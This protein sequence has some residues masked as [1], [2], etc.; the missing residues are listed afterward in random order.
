MGVWRE[1]RD[2]ET[3]SCPHGAGP[4]MVA[5]VD[6]VLEQAWR[7]S[8][9]SSCKVTLNPFGFRANRKQHMFDFKTTFFQSPIEV[10]LHRKQNVS[11][12]TL[13]KRFLPA[14]ICQSCWCLRR[15]YSFLNREAYFESQPPTAER[16]FRTEFPFCSFYLPVFLLLIG[17]H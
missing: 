1:S 3:L 11:S 2:E 7:H 17:L 14:H 15:R 8:F 10:P 5:A 6:G 4:W 9:V 12:Y 16:L 13:Q